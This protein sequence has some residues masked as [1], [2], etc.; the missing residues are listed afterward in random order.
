MGSDRLKMLC[1]GALNP[2]LVL[3][4]LR[5]QA[6]VTTIVDW[7]DGLAAEICASRRIKKFQLVALPLF[8]TEEAWSRS[9]LFW[10]Y[11]ESLHSGARKHLA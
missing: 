7:Y 6:D 4:T 10:K 2:R 9:S 3:E 1:E 5:F 8:H 11:V